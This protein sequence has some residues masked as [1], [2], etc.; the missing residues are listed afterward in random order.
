MTANKKCFEFNYSFYEDNPDDV[1]FEDIEFPSEKSIR[2][3]ATFSEDVRWTN[4][5]RE[6]ASFLDSTGYVGVSDAI[7]KFIDDKDARMFGLLNKE[8]DEDTSNPGLSD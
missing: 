6:F 4:I 7:A 5:L 3:R 2:F 8:D 1:V